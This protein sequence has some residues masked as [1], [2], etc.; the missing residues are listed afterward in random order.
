MIIAYSPEGEE[1]KSWDLGEVKLMA[2][3]AETIERLTDWTWSEITERLAKGSMIALRSVV[4]VLAKRDDPTLRYNQFN[5]PTTELD[6]WLDAEER[7]AMR[8]RVET[9]DL[10]EAERE[11]VLQALDGLDAE[12]VKRGYETAPAIN[13]ESVPKDS[14]STASPTAA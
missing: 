12:M 14:G 4:F 5:P 3:E 13:P 9:A 2:T 1:P 8:E 6:Y 11:R 10:S 7:E